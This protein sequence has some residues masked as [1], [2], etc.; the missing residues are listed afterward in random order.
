MTKK[1]YE[2]TVTIA[3]I[4]V[5]NEMAITHSINK[6]EYILTANDGE[7]TFYAEGCFNFEDRFGETITI[8]VKAKSMSSAIDC[9]INKMPENFILR[10]VY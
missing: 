8:K 9:V 2:I 10:E 5:F 1:F 3:T 4:K 6:C 7:K